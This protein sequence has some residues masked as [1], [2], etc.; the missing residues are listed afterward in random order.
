M[1]V[2]VLFSG[3][4]RSF[5]RCKETFI[6]EF[7]HFSPDYY[8]TT[9]PERYHFKTNLNFHG[10]VILDEETIKTFFTDIN[11]KH[12]IVDNLSK[13]IEYFNSEKEKFDSK[14]LNNGS[15]DKIE[16]NHF[17]QFY[18]IKKALELI[19][20]YELLLNKKYDVII[21]SRMDLL[22]KNFATLDLSNLKNKV[23]VGYEDINRMS[24]VN[25][26]QHAWQDMLM[27]SSPDNMKK[28]IDN[29][30]SEFYCTTIEKSVWGYPHGI[31]ESGIIKSN[32]EVDNINLIHHI[33]RHDDLILQVT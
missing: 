25:P 15:N 4:I 17:L 20:D 22:I 18:K 7:E 5:D 11:P 8:V 3:N 23:I 21:R 14:I 2:A 28:I 6:K 27:V 32:L 31:F 16:S 29:L 26:S 33:K 19:S 24:T 30:L 10:E 1:N 13:M 9:Y 12:I